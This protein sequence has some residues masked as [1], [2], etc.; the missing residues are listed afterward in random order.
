M[1]KLEI[2]QYSGRRGLMLFVP[3]DNPVN[4][5]ERERERG[6]NRR[7]DLV[8][9]PTE[10]EAE[11]GLGVGQHNSDV[12]RR[13]PDLRCEWFSVRDQKGDTKEI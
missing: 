9:I 6:R 3:Q 1:L 2:G 8:A 10:R 4:D 7:V 11:R 13:T 5:A 12:C